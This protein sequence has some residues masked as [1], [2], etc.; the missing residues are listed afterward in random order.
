MH[1]DTI[2]IGAGISGMLAA[3]GR[4]EAGERV[5]VLAKGHAATHWSTG[6]VDLL[7]VGDGD[8]LAGIATLIAA[9]PDHPY[10]LAGYAAIEPGLARLQEICEAG[11]YPLVGNPQRN[12]LLPTAAGALRPTCLV[13]TTMVAGDVRQLPR[14]GSGVAPLGVV[15]FHELRDFFPP[16]I[17]ANLQLQGIAAQ[18]HYL[19]MPPMEKAPD[20]TTTGFAHLFEQPDF[21]AE[22]AAQLRHLVRE[23]GYQRIAMP[24]VLGLRQAGQVVA[25]LQATCG[26]LIFEI[27]TPPPSVPGMRIY[28]C[29]EAALQRAGGRI[30]LGAFV[31]RGEA[32]GDQLEAVYSAAAAR[33]QRHRARR[34]VLAT[35]GIAGG[36]VRAI[37][38]NHL[39]ETVLRLPLR[40]PASRSDWFFPDFLAQPGHPIFRSGVAVDAH[41][42]PL[43]ARNQIVYTNVAV[44]G[45]SIAGCDHIREGA[46]E[47]VA[48]ATGWVAGAR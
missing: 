44:V 9:Q 46:Y 30:Q 47:G 14:Q 16:M 31:Q 21:R 10:A 13:P 4:T 20:L 38:T 27:P 2:V 41:L 19:R 40:T 23:E 22:V 11:G 12:L 1:Y 43:D 8:P 39:I 25:E 37:D 34:F 45:A 32:H 18:S 7:D 48:V 5:L 33:E 35:G 36:G 24:A 42:R 6:C 15:G 3:I 17:A 28:H 26:A 29:L